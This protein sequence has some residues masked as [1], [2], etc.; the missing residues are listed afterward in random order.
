[1]DNPPNRDSDDGQAPLV[2]D[3]ALWLR[4]LGS[5]AAADLMRIISASGGSARGNA[6]N[7]AREHGRGWGDIAIAVALSR[8]AYTGALPAGDPAR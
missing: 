6:V 8:C 3:P 1:M 4:N 7:V 5:D 2:R